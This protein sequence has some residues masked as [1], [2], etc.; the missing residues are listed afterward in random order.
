MATNFYQHIFDTLS[1]APDKVCIRWPEAGK[2]GVPRS[3][4]ARELLDKISAFR[5][6]LSEKEIERGAHVVI[7]AAVDINLLCM[8]LATMGHGAVPVLPPAGIRP[9]GLL[10]LL[11]KKEVKGLFV[12]QGMPFAAGLLRLLFNVELLT[13]SGTRN[14]QAAWEPAL[15]VEA[16]QAALISHSSGSTGKPKAIIRSHGTLQAQHEALKQAFPP[17]NGQRDFPLFPNILLHNL[18]V[19]VC[20][21]IP[22]IP[23]FN[24]QQMVPEKVLTQIA[25]EAVSTLTGN[26]YYFKKL[27]IYLQEYPATL[28]AVKALGIGGSPVPEWLLHS[29]KKYFPEATIYAIYGSTEAEPIAIRS[30]TAAVHEPQRGYGVGRFHQALQWRIRAMGKLSVFG[31][32]YP[33]GEVEVKGPHVVRKDWG[34]WLATGDFGYVDEA[35]QL[36]LTGR[37]G[38]EAIHGGVQHYQLEHFLQEMEGVEAVAAIAGKKGFKVYIKGSVARAI[39][40]SRLKEAFPVAIIEAVHFRKYIPTDPRHHSKVLY[41]KVK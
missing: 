15:A 28:P 36:F 27:L 37:K 33:V 38:N 18:S 31:K 10:R 41:P 6:L 14:M 9:T 16:A 7:A 13:V 5:Q 3:Y 12:L 19:G 24:V 26:V 34:G 8:L 30:V 11:R 29:C 21:I 23:R 20:S 4:T 40:E 2:Q 1:Y 32:T 17:F 35:G 25:A 39:I 22:D